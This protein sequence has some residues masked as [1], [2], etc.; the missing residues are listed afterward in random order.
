LE[1]SHDILPTRNDATEN[2]N[3]GCDMVAEVLLRQRMTPASYASIK[4]IWGNRPIH[5]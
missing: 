1:Q 5:D 2:H 4:R 3:S